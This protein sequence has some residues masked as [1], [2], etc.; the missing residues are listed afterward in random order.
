MKRGTKCSH[1]TLQWFILVHVQFYKARTTSRVDYVLSKTVVKLYNVMYTCSNSSIEYK[2]KHYN[3]VGRHVLL[4]LR[5]YE[6]NL[7]CSLQIK[8]KPGRTVF[9]QVYTEKLIQLSQ[10]HLS[11]LSRSLCSPSTPRV[12]TSYQNL[13]WTRIVQRQKWNL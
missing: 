7:H 10:S 12:E 1:T 11:M 9:A 5:Q 13:A 3:V 4:N 2:F 6:W 8:L